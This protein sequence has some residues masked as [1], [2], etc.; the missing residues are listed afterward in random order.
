MKVKAIKRFNDKKE[1]VTRKTGDTFI[2]SK[3][4]FKEINSTHDL[5]E[6]VKEEESKSG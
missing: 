2:V 1:G 6:E 5:V 3:E 4:R